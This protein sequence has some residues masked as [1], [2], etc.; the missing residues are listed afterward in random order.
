MIKII[1]KVISIKEPKLT[2]NVGSGL[3]IKN[4]DIAKIILKI[5]KK[6]NLLINN[7]KEESNLNEF[8]ASTELLKNKIY[9]N[10]FTKIEEGLKKIINT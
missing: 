4:I 7:F 6:E 1:D 8:F 3:L 9:F 2:L 10:K 5:F